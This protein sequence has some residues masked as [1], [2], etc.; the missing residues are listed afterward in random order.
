MIDLD[1]SYLTALM[2]SFIKMLLHPPSF[3]IL[4][5][6]DSPFPFLS[7]VISSVISFFFWIVVT[8]EA[9]PPP[10]RHGYLELHFLLYE[11]FLF[12]LSPFLTGERF[13]SFLAV[14]L[15]V[16]TARGERRVCIYRQ[17]ND[18]GM[19]EMGLWIGTTGVTDVFDDC[20]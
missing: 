9:S 17:G 4:L 7:L 14:L 13:C 18:G 15:L 5:P 19:Q 20:F 12:I 1:F 3:S 2:V 6:I 16:F 11:L 10:R 8:K